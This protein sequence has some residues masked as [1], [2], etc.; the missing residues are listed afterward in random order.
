MGVG[1][2]VGR[3]SGSQLA[4]TKVGHYFHLSFLFFLFFFL[5]SVVNVSHGSAALI[6]KP[7]YQKLTEASKNLEVDPLQTPSAI[8]GPHGGHFGF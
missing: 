2:A 3:R 6:K 4:T 8:L 7:S 1:V 5:L